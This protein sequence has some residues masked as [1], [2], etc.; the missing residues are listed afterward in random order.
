MFI[1]H[2]HNLCRVHRGTAADSDNGIRLERFHTFNALACGAECGI[3]FNVA[4]D[5]EL[6]VH[7]F[8]AFDQSVDNAGVEEEAVGNDECT[9]TVIV[10]Q[11]AQSFIQ[12]AVFKINLFRNPEPQHVFPPFGSSF[13]IEQM[14]RCNVLADRVTAPRTAT[15]SKRRVEFE[16]E[17]VADSALAGRHI[18]QGTASFHS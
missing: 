13:D 18:N 15:E 7:F 14:F 8:E 12:A 6:E 2:P 17:H 3:R 5:F 10:G 11:V 4:E 9:F 16:V 1:K